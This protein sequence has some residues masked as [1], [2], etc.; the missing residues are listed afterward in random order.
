NEEQKE[1]NRK[2][3]LGNVYKATLSCVEV[4]CA[5]TLARELGYQFALIGAVKR[6]GGGHMMGVKIIETKTL[7][8]VFKHAKNFRQG[9]REVIRALPSWGGRI[10]RKLADPNFPEGF[11][12]RKAEKTEKVTKKEEP[13]EKGWRSGNFDP[14]TAHLLGTRISGTLTDTLKQV[15]SPYVVTGNIIIPPGSEFVIEKGV[16]LYIGGEYTTITVMGQLFIKGT[17]KEPVK[18]LSGKKNPATWDWDRIY[19]RSKQRSVLEYVHISHSNYGVVVKNGAVTLSHCILNKNSVRGV[20]AENSDVEI[21]DTKIM[22]GHLIGV[23][24]G[25]YGEVTIRRSEITGNHNGVSILDFGSV[26]MNQTKIFN[27]ER[28]LILVDSISLAMDNCQIREN[29]I[30]VVSNKSLSP[31]MFKGLKGNKQDVENI[32]KEKIAALIQK[33]AVVTT[34]RTIEKDIKK[35]DTPKKKRKFVGGVQS[36]SKQLTSGLIGNVS[37]GSEYH[38][39]VA[40]E[41]TNN[42]AIIIGSDTINPGE[43]VPQDKVIPGYYQTLSMFSTLELGKNVIDGNM[44]LRWDQW[45]RFQLDAISVKTAIGPS[46]IGLGDFNE[47][48]SDISIS[49]ISIRGLKYDLGFFNNR[50]GKARL[51]ISAVGGE[52][53]RP[54]DEGDRVLGS[55]GEHKQSGSAVAQKL[56]GLVRMDVMAQDN[57]DLRFAYIY[58]NDERNGWLRPNLSRTATTTQDPLKSQM[59]GVESEWTFLKEKVSVIAELNMGTVDSTTQAY[60]LSIKKV[61]K[62]RDIGD[63][64]GASSLTA[65]LQPTVT[66]SFIDSNLASAT[67]KFFTEEDSIALRDS[68]LAEGVDSSEIDSELKTE[69]RSIRMSYLNTIKEEAEELEDDFQNDLDDSKVAGFRWNEQGIAGRLALNLNLA[70]TGIDLSYAYIGANYYTGGN[71]YLVK[72]QRKY[73]LSVSR[74]LTRKLAL[75]SDFSLYVENS[76]S[77]G[78]N[79]NL[80]GLG[81]GSWHGFYS[82]N[83]FQKERETMDGLRPKHTY[84]WDWNLRY[85]LTSMIELNVDY[86]FGYKAETKNKEL[87]GDSATVLADAYFRAKEGSDTVYLYNNNYEYLLDKS[88]V[89]QYNEDTQDDTPLANILNDRELY[90]TLGL[91]SKIRFSKYGNF[92]IGGKW[93]WE[94]D[95]SSYKYTRVLDR[96]TLHDSTL[97]H[98]SYYSRGEDEFWQDYNMALTLKNKQL[99]NKI[100]Y[101]IGLKG[102]I[103]RNEDLYTWTLKDKIKWKAIPRKLT[104]E[105]SGAMKR[106][107]TTEEMER[108]YFLDNNDKKWYYF[109]D[110][111]SPAGDEKYTQLFNVSDS[112]YLEVYRGER[113]ENEYEWEAKMRYNFSTK[114]YTEVLFSQ[115]FYLRPEEL[116]QQ[117]GDHFGKVE[118]F[119]SF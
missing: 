61:L 15:N 93:K 113:H 84:N 68:M 38:I 86:I 18:I 90:N 10:A 3:S 58:S 54:Y 73:E 9:K 52:T 78:E 105:I 5:G 102:K 98:L 60:N 92:S 45:G 35:K 40:P 44:D 32:R 79:L 77:D 97:I 87:S 66:S 62:N 24:A 22:G 37:V 103:K 41:N 28:G 75:S 29:R 107:T 94:N 85:N 110:D 104:L 17:E 2:S 81:E 14:F 95:I 63:I 30:G 56:V 50:Q 25:E 69:I 31:E 119:Y 112:T 57:W 7:S 49:S 117:Y 71:P 115:E 6:Q 89:D 23:Q 42:R 55:Y 67:V 114:L 20:Y 1:A 64:D 59:I 74:D 47:S 36:L 65:V 83:D 88:L 13:A 82:D 99:S 70:G 21:N 101:K 116:E 8:V 118:I 72:D 34:R 12:V 80:F 39:P 48:G 16:T 108:Y 96:Y 91:K 51:R 11:G 76:S 43:D 46:R 27:N 109:R 4:E 106:K 19:F 100:E 111:G 33:P 53:E 26:A